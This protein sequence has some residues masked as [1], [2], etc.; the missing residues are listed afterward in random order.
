M[1]VDFLYFT[2]HTLSRFSYYFMFVVRGYVESCLLL[3]VKSSKSVDSES[4]QAAEGHDNLNK[5]FQKK[6]N[7]D[8]S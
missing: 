8:M 4:P 5:T 3:L 2:M 1:A 7:V 6:K